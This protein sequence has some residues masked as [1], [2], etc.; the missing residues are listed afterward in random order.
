[1]LS[2]VPLSG[3][4]GNAGPVQLQTIYSHVCRVEESLISNIFLIPRCD[5]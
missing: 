1:M 4:R 5:W 2:V 3:M